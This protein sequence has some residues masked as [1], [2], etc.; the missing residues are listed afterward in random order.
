VVKKSIIE[1]I[2]DKFEKK[3]ARLQKNV[4]VVVGWFF[5]TIFE[6]HVNNVQLLKTVRF[7]TELCFGKVR[8]VA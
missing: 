1:L 8:K 5:A 4:I 7:P 3:P 2:S 6:S